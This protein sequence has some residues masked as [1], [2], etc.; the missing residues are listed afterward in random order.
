MP[1]VDGQMCMA[2][3]TDN[4]KQCTVIYLL[5]IYYVYVYFCDYKLSEFRNR[6][7]EH[8][9]SNKPFAVCFTLTAKG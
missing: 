8:F 6:Q 4:P 7:T 9:D 2:K 3:H 1:T 5:L